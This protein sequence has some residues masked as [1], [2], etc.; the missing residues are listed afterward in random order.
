MR[1]FPALGG[2]TVI[3]GG[4]G[5]S[6]WEV[7]SNHNVITPQNNKGISGDFYGKFNA[8]DNWNQLVGTNCRQTRLDGLFY[9][10]ANYWAYNTYDQTIGDRPDSPNN[11]NGVL[12][13]NTHSGGYGNQIAF[14]NDGHLFTRANAAGVKTPWKRIM[15]EGDTL[16]GIA[17][18]AR[19]W[20]IRGRDDTLADV[21]IANTVGAETEINLIGL[22]GT[23]SNIELDKQSGIITIPAGL[24]SIDMN[25]YDKGGIICFQGFKQS[26]TGASG[27][28]SSADKAKIKFIVMSSPT[29]QNLWTQAY[30]YETEPSS[31]ASWNDVGQI[32]MAFALPHKD[33]ATDYKIKLVVSKQ[34][35]HNGSTAG[36]EMYLS[37]FV[38]LKTAHIRRVNTESVAL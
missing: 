27:S 5:G 33:V 36:V 13:F 18:A 4:G 22:T 17:D 31:Y 32:G 10:I 26:A 6:M 16:G 9:G 3:Q 2:T 29:G 23:R 19:V 8:V 11:A 21:M 37:G 24:E 12:S 30:E 20:E 35:T 38:E 14:N 28:I 15:L 7:G 1:N 34:A 25:S